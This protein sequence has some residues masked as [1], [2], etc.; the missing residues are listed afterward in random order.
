MH[1]YDSVTDTGAQV[2]PKMTSHW[3]RL[4]L[5]G[6][7]RLERL[8]GVYEL[9]DTNRIPGGTVKIKVLERSTDFMA[10]PNVCTRS[11]SGE[12][13]WICGLGQSEGEALQDAI[14][15]I[16]S[17]LIVRSEWTEDQLEWADPTVF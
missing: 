15:R 16:M 10:L 3:K 8:C 2:L 14:A 4:N 13:D 5:H 7:L 17:A 1:L 6:A 11:E 12:P 9:V